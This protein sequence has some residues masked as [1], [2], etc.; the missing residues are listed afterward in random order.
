MHGDHGGLRRRRGCCAT[1][2]LQ[3][4]CVNR[5]EEGIEVS[6]GERQHYREAG[7]G[8]GF[9][10]RPNGGVRAMTFQIADDLDLLASARRI[11]AK[12]HRVVLEGEVAHIDLKATHRERHIAQGRGRAR[13]ARPDQASAGRAMW[14]QPR[15]H[16]RHA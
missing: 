3:T 9:G 5:V 6:G 16:R 7:G 15:R 1:T 12:G 10:W 4:P 13:D 11:T 2:R 8:G 14:R